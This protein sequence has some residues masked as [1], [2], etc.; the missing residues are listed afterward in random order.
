MNELR[1]NFRKYKK[2]IIQAIILIIFTLI[3]ILVAASLYFITLDDG[4]YKEGDMGNVPYA[5]STYIKGIKFTEDGIKFIYTHT[6]ETTGELLSE[7]KTSS[8]MAQIVWDEM[9]KSGTTVGN[10]LNSVEELEELMN[11][12]VITQYPKLDK[13]VE[14]NGTIE[15]ERRKTDGTTVKL[16]FINLENF[17]KYIENKDISIVNYYTMDENENILIGV[18][19]QTTETLTS[20]DSDMVLSDYADSLSDS[21][22]SNT[23]NYSKTEYNVYSKSINYKSIVSKYTMPFQYL[24]SFIVTGDDKE[25]GLDLAKLVENSEIVISIFDNITENEDV[26]TY[27]YKKERK[28]NVSATATSETNYGKYT[29]TGKWEKENAIIWKENDTYTIKHTVTYKNNKPIVDITKADVWIVDYSKEYDYN[30][31]SQTSQEINSSDLDDTEYV[32]DGDNPKT[33]TNGDGKDLPYY[34][35]FKGELE[36]LIKAL[37]KEI[38]KNV[39]LKVVNGVTDKL[40]MSTSITSCEASYYK[41]QVEKKEKDVSTEYSQKYVA[42]TPVNNPKVEKKTEEE[43]KKGTGQDNFVTILCDAKHANARDK[44]TNDVTDWLFELLEEN[45]DTVNM[46]DLTS[47]LLYK[48]TGDDK[49]F[50]DSYDFSEYEKND[51]ISVGANSSYGDWTGEGSTNDFIKAVAPYAVID[52]QQHNIYASVTIAQAIIESGWGKDSIAINYKN[53]FGMKTRGISNTGNEY[54]DG[55]GVALNASEGGTS[56]FRVYDSLANSVYDHGRNF[57][58]T[59]TYSAHGVLECMEKNLGPKEQL[60]RIALSGYAVMRD[61]SISKPDGVHT[62]DEYLYEKFIVKYNLTQ[63]DSMSSTDFEAVGNGDIVDIAKSKIGCAYQLG[64]DGPNTFDCSGLVYWVFGQKGISVPRST[65][66]YSS[67][68]GSDKEISWEE[69]QPGDILIILASE[70]GTT[71]GHAAIYLGNNEYIHA[72][73]PGDS[74]KISSGA[75]SHFKHVFR[76]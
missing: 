27:T 12:E 45:P 25:V 65:T 31:L 72:P 13:N 16:Q 7:T 5:A 44:I 52:M 57:H 50:N 11:A 15:F 47:Y 41:H 67:Y 36:G 3:L 64:A 19:D 33:S 49:R 55:T 35:K 75:T 69:A 30:P 6:D 63:Y 28:A 71:Y 60:R 54:W 68:I 23:G 17:N 14:L 74:V 42:K 48:V 1:A 20:D 53:F 58:V 43:I 38:E 51:F 4:T 26:S 56:Y 70:R 2:R 46:V 62:Y 9:Y 59:A 73:K 24:W 22:M 21:D 61:G 76:F 29:K 37:E 18:V 32:N 8:E 39:K 10:Y 34:D 66:S 40:T